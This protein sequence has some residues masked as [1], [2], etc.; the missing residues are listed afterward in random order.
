MS[1]S[2]V[3]FIIVIFLIFV[4]GG[5]KGC[6]SPGVYGANRGGLH[7]L[8]VGLHASGASSAEID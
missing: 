3:L 1:K 2:I 8:A 7:G 6:L 5:D 4:R